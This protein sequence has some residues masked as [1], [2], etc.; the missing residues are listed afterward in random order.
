MTAAIGDL[1][2]GHEKMNQR[3]LLGPPYHLF[4]QDLAAV[5]SQL[6]DDPVTLRQVMPMRAGIAMVKL[7]LVVA[8]NFAQSRIVEKQMAVFV[9]DQ[10][11]CR[12]ELQHFTKLALV[13]GRLDP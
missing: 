4:I 10:E 8:Q 3:A 2:V 6:L 11:C 12:A 9:D 5:I 1:D 7:V 13:L